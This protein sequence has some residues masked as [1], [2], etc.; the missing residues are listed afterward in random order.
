VAAGPFTA[1]VAGVSSGCSVSLRF[2]PIA[3][4]IAIKGFSVSEIGAAKPFGTN[5]AGLRYL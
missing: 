4:G 2:S 1:D 5:A 3:A